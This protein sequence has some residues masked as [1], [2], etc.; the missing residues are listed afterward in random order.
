[1][2]PYAFGPV[3]LPGRPLMRGSAWFWVALGSP[4][5]LVWLET[6]RSELFKPV[7]VHT[8]GSTLALTGTHSHF[9]ADSEEA[10]C[11]PERKSE[12]KDGKENKARRGRNTCPPEPIIWLCGTDTLTFGQ[13]ANLAKQ[14]QLER[15]SGEVHDCRAR[16]DNLIKIKNCSMQHF[17]CA[18]HL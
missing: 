17:S 7:P 6:E 11:K 10:K 8:L 5:L 13:Q 9:R 15:E 14:K 3:S 12:I 4:S 16:D 1:M 2:Q 18:K